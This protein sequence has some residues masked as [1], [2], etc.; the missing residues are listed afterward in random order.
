ML[1]Q[2]AEAPAGP[3]HADVPAPEPFLIIRPMSRRAER[4]ICERWSSLAKLL[5]TL[6]ERNLELP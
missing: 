6:A 1:S 5:F 2:Q 4:L 3:S